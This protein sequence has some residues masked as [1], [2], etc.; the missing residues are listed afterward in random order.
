M[1]FDELVA[2]VKVVQVAIEQRLTE[3]IRNR[4]SVVVLPETKNTK[5]RGL[6]NQVL[7]WFKQV[8]ST[9]LVSL[10]H[11]II[12]HLRDRVDF[13]TLEVRKEF[14]ATPFHPVIFKLHSDSYWRVPW[15]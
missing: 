8:S 13:P 14:R 1:S 6:V 12:F 7:N 10:E 9:E 3:L 15:G 11:G 5:E 2:M 4:R